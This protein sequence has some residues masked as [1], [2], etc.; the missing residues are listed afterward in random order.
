MEGIYII[1]GLRARAMGYFDTLPV[2]MGQDG[3]LLCKEMCL[4]NN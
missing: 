4:G 3:E 2:E 1:E